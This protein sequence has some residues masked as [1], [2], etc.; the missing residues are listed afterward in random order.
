MASVLAWERGLRDLGK[1]VEVI[2]E[3]KKKEGT[4][5]DL[6]GTVRDAQPQDADRVVDLVYPAQDDGV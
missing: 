4:N 6:W 5:F 3:R 1:R 2:R